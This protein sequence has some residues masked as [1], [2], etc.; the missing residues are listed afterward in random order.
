L[1]AVKEQ[2]RQIPNRGMGF[3]VLR[4]LNRDINPQAK[5]GDR[6]HP[7]V[8][9]NYLGQFDQTLQDSPLFTWSTA[10]PRPARSPRGNRANLVE[11]IGMINAGML[12]MQWHY[13]ENIHRRATMEALANT[14]LAALRALILHCQ[15]PEAG[16]YTPSDFPLAKI[17]QHDLDEILTHL[18][19]E[20]NQA[21]LTDLYPLTPLQ[22]GI[23]F[24][25]LAAPESGI[26]F[27]RIVSRLDGEMDLDLL[28]RAWEQVLGRHGILR[29]SL[30]WEGLDQPLQIV[31]PTVVLPWDQQDWRDRAAMEEPERLKNFLEEDRARGFDFTQPPLMRLTLIQIAESKALL[32]WSYHHVILDRWSIEVVQKEVWATY[33]ALR[34]GRAVPDEQPRPFREYLKWLP[35][36]DLVEAERYW[37]RTLKGFT[38]PTLLGGERESVQGEHQ[39][40]H[41]DVQHLTLS[42]PATAALERFA[43]QH[44][45]TLNTLVQGAWAVLLSRYG[46]T[47]DVVFGITS[48]GR[49][50]ELQDME[51]MVGMFINTLP[52]RVQVDQSQLVAM[53][54]KEM[55]TQQVGMRQ[56]EYTPLFEIQKW[57]EVSP[58]MP[59]FNTLLIF[60]NTPGGNV[61]TTGPEGLSVQQDFVA[62]DLKT[63]YPLNLACI[64]DR[65]LHMLITYDTEH[66]EAAA[67]GQVLSHVQQVLAEM[68]AEPEQRISDVQILTDAERQQLLFDWNDT[69]SEYPRDRCVHQLFEQQV[70]QS[71]DAVAVVYGDQQLTYREL[72]T[73]ANQLARY[74]NKLGVGP[75]VL[76]G[77]CLERSLEMV[78]GVLGILKAG[79]AYVPLDP[80]YPKE[81]LN[82]ILND[83]QAE[84]LLTENRLSEVI[85]ESRAHT[86]CLDADRGSIAKE[87]KANPTGMAFAENLAYV[88][89][90]SGS[91]G[92]PK[93]VG[94]TH[95]NT[96]ALLY[97]AKDVFHSEDLAGVL[98][99]TSIC[100]DLSVFELFFPLSRGGK[101]ILAENVLQ[102]INLPSAKDV[103]LINTVPSAIAELLR[104]D[105]VP[106]SVRTINLAGEPLKNNIVKQIYQ[107]SKVSQVFDL[108]GPSEDTTY[109]TFALRDGDRSATIGRPI[110]NS[111][112]YL[113]DAHMQPVP[114]GV[115]G[116]IYIGGDG[117]ARGYLNRPELTA[118]KFIPDPFSEDPATRLYKTGDL[119]RYLPDGNIEFLGRIDHQVKIRGFR[120]E[121]GEIESV[122]GRHPTVRETVVIA[123]ED[124]PGDKRLVA[125]VVASHEPTPT[126]S[127]L[128]S[129]LKEK[130]PD[131]M[132][133][134][135]FVY[136]D[137]L[138]LTPNGKLDRRALPRPEQSRSELEAVYVA[139]QSEVERII[140]EVWQQVLRVEQV[141]VHDNFFDLGGH[142]LLLIQ[143]HNK[144][145]EFFRKTIPI[146]DIF[147]YPTIKALADHLAQVENDRVSIQ[148]TNDS[149]EKL[150][151]GKNRMKQL[152]KRRQQTKEKR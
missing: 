126:F 56:Y 7:E 68:V 75:E 57:S 23:W 27:R 42:E 111:Q 50:A 1:K 41:Y 123:R 134:S 82:F 94:I 99:S 70:E 46:D 81:R 37:R 91:T 9:F 19:T 22:Q 48:S 64:A 6:V 69:S 30:V 20:G 25:E 16:G 135:A 116:E 152:Y 145:Q 86:V 100:F 148:Q 139:P 89:Y 31:H 74:L 147:R 63:N 110:S 140:A 29:T 26:Y 2:L 128:R 32:V 124:V 66:F 80:S 141:G 93:G 72:N 43:R 133:P 58:G 55:Q 45:V 132:I 125:Y 143:I 10:S 149:I 44:Q 71:P 122:L 117:L 12:Q 28:K 130:L 104:I 109:S 11:I 40:G 96:I 129:F 137:S 47:D 13:S 14:Y 53:W 76:V 151:E 18:P 119:A 101:V 3:G 52:V 112:I 79:G 95:C 62:S 38:A 118:E 144:F 106:D 61:S 115:S 127:E 84:V 103:T 120:I 51:T 150:T 67:I 24:H 34:K 138:P 83:S 131:Y 78:V 108:Y 92:R 5:F 49:T 73:R 102:L 59:L 136:L 85:L 107:A 33:Q 77:I 21:E 39:P 113:L 88:I 142:S 15:S 60:E 35:K 146:T 54:L 4:Y 97:W 105:G 65:P 90:T 114:V 17:S 87:S 98:A 36:Q 8:S 121:L